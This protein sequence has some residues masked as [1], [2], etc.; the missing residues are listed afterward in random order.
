MAKSYIKKLANLTDGTKKR[1]SIIPES[2]RS[3]PKHFESY[4][5]IIQL[6]NQKN[7]I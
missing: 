7:G 4:S 6:S 2:H 5:S 1:G 3:K